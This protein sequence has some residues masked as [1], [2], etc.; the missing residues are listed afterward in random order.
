[1]GTFFQLF[2][3]KIMQRIVRSQTTRRVRLVRQFASK[4]GTSTQS[5]R[6]RGFRR[7]LRDPNHESVKSTRELFAQVDQQR[8]IVA[9]QMKSM[10]YLLAE[11]KNIQARR[12]PDKKL[13]QLPNIFAGPWESTKKAIASSGYPL[14][15]TV[16]LVLFVGFS[17]YEPKKKYGSL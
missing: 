2:L 4:E 8:K 12:N 11:S 6:D 17:F 1:M 15:A 7:E 16:A 13:E 9:K 3:Q 14:T 10:F 5:T